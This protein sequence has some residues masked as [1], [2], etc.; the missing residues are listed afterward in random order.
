MSIFRTFLILFFLGLV[1]L[2][3]SVSLSSAAATI[4]TYKDD[5]GTPNFTTEL[6]SIPERYRRDRK[7]TRLNSSH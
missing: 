6:D 7:S 4:Y 5:S 3:S 2:A 1:V